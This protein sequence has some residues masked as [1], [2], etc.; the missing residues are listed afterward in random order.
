MKITYSGLTFLNIRRSEYSSSST[1]TNEKSELRS[2]KSL[3]RNKTNSA[4]PVVLVCV[5]GGRND[6]PR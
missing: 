6:N 2:F 1:K 3:R 5:D 4:K